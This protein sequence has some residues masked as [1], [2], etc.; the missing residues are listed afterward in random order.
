[1]SSLKLSKVEIAV[2]ALV[3]TAVISIFAVVSPP[4]PNFLF[5]YGLSFPRGIAFFST[6]FLTGA[7]CALW[8]LYRLHIWR[9]EEVRK[10][11]RE[12]ANKSQS[13]LQRHLNLLET[14]SLSI[15]AKNQ[16]KEAVTERLQ[17]NA[18]ELGK[19]FGASDAEINALRFGALFDHILNVAPNREEIFE[20]A[21]AQANATRDSETVEA[22][23]ANLKEFGKYTVHSE[24]E[25]Q[26]TNPTLKQEIQQ[27][28]DESTDMAII[29]NHD[30][31]EEILLLGELANSFASSLNLNETM[32][33][34]T[35]KLERVVPFDS[36][37]FYLKDKISRNAFQAHITAQNSEENARVSSSL[38]EGRFDLNTLNACSLNNP[39]QI[40]LYDLSE[41][42]GTDYKC[43]L[44][45]PL[46]YGN[47][48]LGA[49]TL[50]NSKPDAYTS[51]HR[52]LLE[53]AS[54]HAA[55]AIQNAL[56]FEKN[57]E[58]AFFDNLTGL[59][60]S[61]AF[62]VTLDQR[63]AECQRLGDSGKLT[64]LCIDVDNFT[65]INETHG[66]SVGDKLLA[67]V[68]SVIQAQLRSMD[69]LARYCGDE[70]VAI[71]PL[72]S[73]ETAQGISERIRIAIE[74]KKL[75][76]GLSS[77][78]QVGISVGT[79]SYPNDGD[80]S[81]ELLE[82]ASRNMYRY[83]QLRKMLVLSDGKNNVVPIDNFR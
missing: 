79:A 69:S 75:D 22:F 19:K 63:I 48:I 27:M 53:L 24:Q 44:S 14:I 49:L 72:A 50:Y 58:S 29:V 64:V 37:V 26:T 41:N 81:H 76:V 28:K 43:A 12:N 65:K 31:E 16:T 9:I 61:R 42:F 38:E 80:T 35:D 17:T 82:T 8:F 78:M 51:E 52:R 55:R 60:N 47:S 62:Y 40:D 77:P 32:A 3:C 4:I 54:R 33:L 36:C 74:T 83:K 45:V 66:H 57:R 34:V 73:S 25:G 59:L 1:M 6:L 11:E 71:L 10:T 68:A 20:I 23:I 15:E 7:L 39:Q 5:G 13:E 2:T 67:E 30:I 21:R 18:T 56:V 70:F 46:K